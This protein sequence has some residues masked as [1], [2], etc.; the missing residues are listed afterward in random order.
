MIKMKYSESYGLLVDEV[1]ILENETPLSKIK[2]DLDSIS[3]ISDGLS[4]SPRVNG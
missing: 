4:L 3:Q 2:Q 1:D